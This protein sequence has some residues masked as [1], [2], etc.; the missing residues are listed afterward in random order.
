MNKESIDSLFTYHAP[1]GNQPQMYQE[2]RGK[3][4]EFAHM[5]NEMVPD[6][7]EKSLALT[8]LQETIMWAN[9]GIAVNMKKEG[10]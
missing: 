4:R 6:S 7:R 2:L 3:A 1:H 10:E 8:K 5:I 9:S